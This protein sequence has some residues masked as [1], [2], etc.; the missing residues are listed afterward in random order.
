MFLITGDEKPTVTEIRD[1]E[2]HG[3]HTVNP[4]NCIYYSYG[5]I[6]AA[7]SL[8]TTRCDLS[9]E[10]LTRNDKLN[11]TS[12]TL[13]NLIKPKIIEAYCWHANAF[14]LTNK[15]RTTKL[16]LCKILISFE[17]ICDKIKRCRI[18]RNEMK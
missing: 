10:T 4:T 1:H 17:C 2:S 18:V 5:N 9:T 8:R 16:T 12:T 3:Y 11:E 6:R 7:T 13:E 14:E 15:L